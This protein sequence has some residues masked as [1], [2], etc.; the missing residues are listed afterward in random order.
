MK[1][2]VILPN[3]IA[4]T[5]YRLTSLSDEFSGSLLYRQQGNLCLVETLF[6]T[7]SGNE[8]GVETDRREDEIL[9]TFFREFPDYKS[10]DVHT[11]TEETVRTYG[12]KYSWNFSQ[13]D[14]T[15]MEAKL[16]ENLDYMAMLVTPDTRILMGRDDPV[17]RVEDYRDFKMY[18]KL[19]SEALVNIR[20]NL[21]YHSWKT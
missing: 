15:T 7:G 18:E 16:R 4:D 14:A 9:N 10:I 13:G 2:I 19:V 20:R 8:G 21:W 6:G 3:E 17:L 12:E 5:L 1:R 11:H